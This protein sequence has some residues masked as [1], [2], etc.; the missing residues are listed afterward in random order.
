MVSDLNSFS[1]AALRSSRFILLIALALTVTLPPPQRVAGSPASLFGYSKQWGSF[2]GPPAPNMIAIDASG[3]MYVADSQNLA[4]GKLARNGTLLALWGQGQF[5][6]PMGIA[7]DN[8]GNYVYAS[9]SINN[10]VFQYDTSGTLVRTWNSNG[11]GTLKG[12]FQHPQGIAVNSTGYVYIVDQGNRR[13]GIFSSTGTFVKYFALASPGNFVSALGIAIDRQGTVY[14]DDSTASLSDNYAGNITQFTKNGAFQ[15]TWGNL[16]LPQQLAVDNSSNIYAADS[17]TG[18]VQKFNINNQNIVLTIGSPGTGTGQLSTPIGVALDGLGSIFV[19]DQANLNI[20]KFSA[21]TGSYLGP[22]GYQQAGHFVAPN[23]IATDGL[24]NVYVVDSGNDRVQKF[25]APSGEFITAWG[26]YG[27]LPGQF[28]G[29]SGVAVDHAGRVYVTDTGNGRVEKYLANGTFSISWSLTTVPGDLGLPTPFGIAADSSN[30]LYV[31][32]ATNGRVEKF[33][34]TG[35]LIQQWG[36]N[37]SAVGTFYTPLG[38]AVDSANTVYVADTGNNRVQKFTSTGTFQA[39]WGH[40]NQP[41][42]ISTD[43]AGNIYVV[44]T[45][46]STVQV[47]AGNRT[48]LTTIGTQGSGNGQFVNPAG[49]AVDISDHVYVTDGNFIV[50]SSVND[51]VEVFAPLHELAV[52]KLTVSRNTSYYGV[53]LI[54]PVKMNITLSNYGLANETFYVREY[55]NALLIGQQNVNLTVG[56]STVVYF[57]WFPTLSRGDYNVTAQVQNVNG[58]PNQANNSVL[59]GIFHISLKGDTNGDCRVDIVDLATIGSDF[60]KT[61]GQAGYYSPADLNNDGMINIV[62]LVL[63]AGA[64]GVTC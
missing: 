26:N 2:G 32:D 62:D 25:N 59:F 5:S 23:G 55:A 38:I 58:D 27:K 21:S 53:P 10:S 60:G 41:E 14:V 39:A 35:S 51:R 56:H 34:N 9:D 46:N 61:A 15:S 19:G 22:I 44:D 30:N 37:G 57:S 13:V 36:T 54:Q 8:I 50:P 17:A 16:L 11:N 40:F 20:Q 49:I 45:L 52:N 47:F 12:Q 3:N 64:F 33:T 31:T 48:L 7:V 28:D 63:V 4:V 43:S 24:G 29:P 6:N 1:K 42:G 18:K